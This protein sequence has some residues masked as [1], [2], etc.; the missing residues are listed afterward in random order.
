MQDKLMLTRLDF[1]H[2]PSDEVSA[3]SFTLLIVTFE[4]QLRYFQRLKMRVVF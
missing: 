1:S 2:F 4:N 3:Q